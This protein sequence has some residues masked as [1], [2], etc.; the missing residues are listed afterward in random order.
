LLCG[1]ENNI[2]VAGPYEIVNNI[3][4]LTG[5]ILSFGAE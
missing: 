2:Y 3:S 1:P 4:P 5:N